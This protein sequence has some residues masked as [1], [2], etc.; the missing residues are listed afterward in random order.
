MS[1][2]KVVLRKRAIRPLNSSVFDFAFITL[3]GTL[4]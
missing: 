4:N 3:P 1:K 2:S